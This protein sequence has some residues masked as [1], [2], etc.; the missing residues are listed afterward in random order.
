MLCFFLNLFSVNSLKY[1]LFQKN[2]KCLNL[3]QY[4][5]K[6]SAFDELNARTVVKDPYCR[7]QLA[8]YPVT[9]C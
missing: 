3:N 6:F 9:V 2:Q 8:I 4:V 1:G 7:Y 5:V